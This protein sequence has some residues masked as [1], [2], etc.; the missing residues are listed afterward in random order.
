[1]ENKMIITIA[2]GFGSGGK[3][4]GRML[5]ERLELP[6]YDRDILSKAS[7]ESGISEALFGEMDERLPRPRIRRTDA[8]TPDELIRPGESGFTSDRNLF[9]YQAKVIKELAASES[10]VI[11]GR[12]AS[13]LITFA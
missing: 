13:S 11:I 6:Y 10:C 12:C 9:N 1:M 2:R 8:Y 4:M 7:E 3:T 5:S